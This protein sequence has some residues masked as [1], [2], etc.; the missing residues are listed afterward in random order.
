[1]SKRIAILSTC[2][3]SE[4]VYSS[5]ESES[6]QITERLNALRS[7]WSFDTFL[8]YV[9]EFPV[10]INQYDGFIFTGSPASVNQDDPWIGQTLAF[11]RE[12]HVARRQMFGICFGHQSIAK[13]LGGKVITSPSGWSLGVVPVQFFNHS[14]WMQP[15]RKEFRLYA[16]HMEQVSTLPKNAETIART[17][18][19]PIAGFRL[20]KHVLTI[21]HH[22]EMTSKFVHRLIEHLHPSLDPSVI[23]RAR[24][25][26]LSQAEGGQFMEW[27]V[28]FFENGTQNN[29][30][31]AS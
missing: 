10:D 29:L 18:A 28:T 12:L 5:G 16:V 1:M 3:G 6:R 26:M 11:I 14:K 23:F 30:S 19:C 7:D 22:P 27:V 4:D 20:G 21:Q 31:Q 13:A 24:E 8:A 25:S 15:E 9:G 2:I 17:S